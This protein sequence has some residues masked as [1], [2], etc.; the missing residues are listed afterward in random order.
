MHFVELLLV[1]VLGAP[2]STSRAFLSIGKVMISLM[3]GS[4]ARSMTMRSTPGAMPACGR[5]AV[6]ECVVQSG[7]L[8]LDDVF[9]VSDD[10]KRSFHNRRLVISHRARRKLHAVDHA[11]VLIRHDVERIHIVER[12]KSALRHRERIVTEAEIA[13]VVVLVHREIH[14][15]AESE[16]VLFK[17]I[18]PRAEFGADITRLL[19]TPFSSASIA[20]KP[21][22][23][24]SSLWHKAS[25]QSARNLDIPPGKLAFSV[26]FE[27]VEIACAVEFRLFGERVN[28]F[29]S[30]P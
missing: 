9:A 5:C 29:F 21:P 14:N 13:F 19:S 20:T 30:S 12:V 11:V 24:R 1:T 2:I 8:L 6:F 10:F 23:F 16:R 7:E 3:L 22:A 18:E 26:E 4:F 25:L 15:P 27:P 28:P 17:Q